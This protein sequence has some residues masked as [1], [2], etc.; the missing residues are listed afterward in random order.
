MLLSPESFGESSQAASTN[1]SGSETLRIKE[2]F[3]VELIVE[4]NA[5]S[6]LGLQI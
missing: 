3:I 1:K 2:R 5:G 6:S 4:R